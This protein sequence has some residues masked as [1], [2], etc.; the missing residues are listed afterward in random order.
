MLG[1]CC[2][3][4]GDAVV[5]DAVDDVGG[6]AVGG[7]V[8]GLD[9]AA[10]VDG[11]VDDDCAFLHFGD[12]RLGDDLGGGGAGDEDST[13]DEVSF[14]DGVLDVVAVGGDG[15]EAA[16]ED[17]VELAE[18]VEVEVDEGDLGAHAEGDFGGVGA[19]DA[20]ADDADVAG[21]DAGNSAEEDAAAA[22][23]LFEVGC[24]DL[25][26]H[27]SGYFAHRGKQRQCAEAVANGL[28][29][30]AGDLVLQQRVGEA[31]DGGK[32]Q[33]GKEDQASRKF[34][35]SFS[36]GSLTLTTMSASRQTS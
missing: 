11:Y 4:I 34:L 16:V 24:A 1:S 3:H 23:F 30:D 31:D 36:T 35:Y 18:A 21:G 28:V 5:D 13:D 14:A 6:V 17:V 19:D 33:V 27:S 26:G 2:G 32:V 25:D 10:L 12:H 22:V 8:G 29:G 20:A 9:A 7:G 15:V